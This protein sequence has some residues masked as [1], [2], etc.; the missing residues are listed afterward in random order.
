MRSLPAIVAALVPV[1]VALTAAGTASAQAPDAATA[2]AL[3]TQ[4]R[5]AMQHGDYLTARA[6]LEESQRLDPTASG[7]LINLAVCDEKTG[8]IAHAWQDLRQALDLLPPG[9]DRVPYV[10]KHL[11]T[12]EPTVPQL[13]L[14]LSP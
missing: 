2:E 7:T 11:K 8:R 5:D 6:K 9:D 3:F 12:I 14:R 10:R 13:T 1:W 4:G